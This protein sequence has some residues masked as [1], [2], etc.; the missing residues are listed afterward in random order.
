MQDT[1]R[2]AVSSKWRSLSLLVLG[3]LLGL[4]M[5]TPVSAHFTTNTTHLGKHVW[6]Q[7]IK[8]KTDKRYADNALQYHRSVPVTV[9][10]FGLA[11]AEAQCPAGWYATGGG[12][13]PSFPS[14]I[15][16]ASY[17]SDGTGLFNAGHTAWSVFMGDLFGAGGAF[18]AY[19]ICA[20]VDNTSGNYVPGVFPFKPGSPSPAESWEGFEFPKSGV[21]LPGGSSE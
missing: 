1:R 19:V 21:K 17:P 12:F 14:L 4:V 18:R 6:R 2:K 20:S 9:A 7:V 16:V 3:L 8:A 13:F 15:E 5:L 10:P 11:G